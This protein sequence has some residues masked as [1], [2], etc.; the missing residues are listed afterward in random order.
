MNK[1]INNS[2]NFLWSVVKKTVPLTLFINVVS[3]AIAYGFYE[4]AF[5]VSLVPFFLAMAMLIFA[6]LGPVMIAT[7]DRGQSRLVSLGLANGIMI[8]SIYFFFGVVCFF[9]YFLFAPMPLYA[10]AGGLVPGIAMTV[11]W[12]V[13]TARDVSRALKTSRFVQQAFEDKGDVLQY[14]LQNIAKLESVLSSR[15]PSGKL[16]MYLVLLIAPLSL[17]IGRVLT[18][19]FGSH[20]PILL[21]ALILFPVSQWIAGI[22]VRQYFVM[23]RLPRMLER[24]QGKSVIVAS[25]DIH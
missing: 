3:I 11:Y 9:F 2:K 17:V 10:R 25:D 1:T 14:R 7:I 15:S 6:A 16:H 20:G 22:G 8:G 19:A 24:T 13:F 18:P 5:R 23:V 4:M 21:A 12:M